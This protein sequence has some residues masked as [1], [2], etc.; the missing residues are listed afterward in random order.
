MADLSKIHV[1]GKE[2][3]PTMQDGAGTLVTPQQAAE[4]VKWFGKLCE[5]GTFDC[6]PQ[7][8][9]FMVKECLVERCLMFGH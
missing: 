8:Y 7:D 6:E 3:V 4:A 5:A 2:E 1:V 9:E